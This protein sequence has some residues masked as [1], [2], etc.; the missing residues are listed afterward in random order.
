MAKKLVKIPSVLSMS[1]LEIAELTGKRH[2]NVVRDIEKM[3][4]DLEIDA[5]NYEAT[6]KDSYKRNKKCYNL[7]K[8][9]TMVLVTGYFPKLRDAVLR[10][11]EEMEKE[12]S[13]KKEKA[14]SRRRSSDLYLEQSAVIDSVRREDGKEVKPYH[15]SNEADM[16]NRIVLGQTAAKYREFN[17][18]TKDA[19]IRN[20]MPRVVLETIAD[21]EGINISLIKIG[22]EYKERKA[23]L[24]AHYMKKHNQ[25][26]IDAYTKSDDL[27]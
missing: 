11:M 27:V 23:K 15:F 20:I 4:S 21:L 25:K 24:E 19:P 1:S 9:Y 22:M 16:I 3:F 8:H 2:D 6:Y 10:R 7:D 13:D 12:L 14:L 17:D 26:L 18:L 5:L